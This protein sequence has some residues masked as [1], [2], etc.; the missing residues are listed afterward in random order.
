MADMRLLGVLLS[1]LFLAGLVFLT[2]SPSDRL[3]RKTSRPR[4]LEESQLRVLLEPVDGGHGRVCRGANS[5][6]NSDAYFDIVQGQTWEACGHLCNDRWNCTGIEYHENGRC[7]LWTRQAG[8]G[9]SSESHGYICARALPISRFSLVDGGWGR[10]CRGSHENDNQGSYFEASSQASLAGCK[11][12]CLAT[13]GCNGIEYHEGAGR[14]EVW[15][16]PV[17]ASKPA[18]GYKCLRLLPPGG[19]SAFSMRLQDTD[20]GG[21]LLKE[22]WASSADAC[23]SACQAVEG[24]KGFSYIHGSCFLKENITGTYENPGCV[25][26]VIAGELSCNGFSEALHDTDLSGDL[27]STEF[28]WSADQCCSACQALA[29]CE[30]Y[31]FAHRTCYLKSHL[32]GTFA[33]PSVVSRVKSNSCGQDCGCHDFQASRQNLDLSGDLIATK[34]SLSGDCCS[35]CSELVGCEGF[36]H[37]GHTCY[38]KANL[39]GLYT[40]EG[41]QIRL[42]SL[43][44]N[45]TD[46]SDLMPDTDVIGDLLTSQF[47]ATAETCCSFCSRTDSCQGFSYFGSMCFLKANISGSYY[48]PG[49]QARLPRELSLQVLTTTASSESCQ[50]FTDSFRDKDL[51]GTLIKDVHAASEETCCSECSATQGCEGTVFLAE[52]YRCYLKRDLTAVFSKSGATARVLQ[53]SDSCQGFSAAAPDSDLAGMALAN[54]FGLS[55][56]QCCHACRHQPGC[57]GFTFFSQVCYLKTNLTGTWSNTGR[58]TFCRGLCPP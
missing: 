25:T 37:S 15:T 33:N 22:V 29:A 55:A 19:C 36:A 43:P 57:H 50:A 27:I 21:D 58:A 14:C 28:A 56:G 16:H 8:I 23:C 40:N 4:R 11:A 9:A 13:E 30:G 44:G 31:A 10:V 3:L 34:F 32:T 12:L 48:S 45:C 7:E 1:L 20:L 53:G 52:F 24:C 54:I 6:D 17:G 26:S 51:A 42:R 18:D 38:F 2:L 39:T 47:S 49:R 35:F 5:R 46:L 41:V